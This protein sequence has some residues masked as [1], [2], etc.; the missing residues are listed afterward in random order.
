MS[1]QDFLGISS[2]FEELDYTVILA[3]P[4]PP[5]VTPT[6]VLPNAINDRRFISDAMAKAKRRIKG[7]RGI[8][9]LDI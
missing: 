9:D 8:Y 3:P 7:H 5:P 4:V 6:E 1:L 2:E